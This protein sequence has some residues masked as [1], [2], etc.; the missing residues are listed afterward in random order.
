MSN[1]CILR[2]RKH[3]SAFSVW[4][5]TRHHN[6]E[7]DCPT[8]TGAPSKNKAF[9]HTSSHDAMAFVK[10]RVSQ[11]DAVN[12]VRS[13]QAVALEYMITA[14]P[15]AMTDHKKAVSYLNAAK[16]WVLKKHGKE[17]TVSVFYHG[18]ETTPH[19][20]IVVIPVDQ[21]GRLSAANFVNGRKKLSSMQTEFHTEVGALFGMDRGIE[22]SGSKHVPVKDYWAALNAPT[23]EP[24]KADY[25]KAAL[26]FKPE[27]II[28]QEQKAQ[29]SLALDRT[30][31][32]TRKRATR[33]CDVEREQNDRA[34]SLSI[35]GA[36]LRTSPS[37]EA[38]KVEN[39]QLKAQ[40]AKYTK[41]S[42]GGHTP[43]KGL[44]EL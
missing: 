9:G 36:K 41:T 4:G 15:E 39:A 28:L 44:F 21:K 30:S 5:V 16:A 38:L 40:L 35:E 26:G 33:V 17:N 7:I 6:R 20:H 24:S 12:K 32:A 22:K 27:S 31:R 29:L 34:I 13:N 18:D 2:V 42:P 10:E 8:T 1:F 3:K 43:G 23:P 14:S 25:A 11:I 37:V 19:L